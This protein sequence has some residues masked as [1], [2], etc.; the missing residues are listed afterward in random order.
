ML[1]EVARLLRENPDLSDC[2]EPQSDAA[3]RQAECAL[4]VTFP[5]AFREYLARWGWVS[6]GPMEYFGLGTT[7]NSVVD[8]TLRGRERANLPESLVTVCDHDGDEYVCIDTK[9]CS[10]HDCQVVIWDVPTA[11]ISRVRAQGFESYLISD[12]RD[13]ID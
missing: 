13:F 7:V 3:I 6:F 8:W 12:I 9:E 10:D 5:R 4:G 1:Q 11:A 2:G